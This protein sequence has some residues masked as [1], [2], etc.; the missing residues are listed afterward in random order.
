[1]DVN[2]KDRGER[3]EDVR[4]GGEQKSQERERDILNEIRFPAAS[5]EQVVRR[6]TVEAM[7]YMGLFPD[8]QGKVLEVN[9]NGAKCSIDILGV[10]AEKTKGNLTEQEKKFLDNTLSSLRI[11]FVKVAEQRGLAAKADKT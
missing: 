3:T 1:M 5:F 4:G 10:L 6:F 11:Q 8:A 9:L 2:N 7:V